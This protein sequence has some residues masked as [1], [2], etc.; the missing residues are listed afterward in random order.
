MEFERFIVKLEEV[1][2]YEGPQK[3]V[4]PDKNTFKVGTQALRELYDNDIE[5][6]ELINN[7]DVLGV[8]RKVEAILARYGSLSE[9]DDWFKKLDFKSIYNSFMVVYNYHQSNDFYRHLERANLKPDTYYDNHHARRYI[10]DYIKED[11][12][13]K[14]CYDQ[15]KNYDFS[16]L[17]EISS[18]MAKISDAEFILS[19]YALMY[20][21]DYL[22]RK[23]RNR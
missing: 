15:V 9:Y 2:N 20:E 11:M 21:P 6:R 13:I 23:E 18:R 19:T 22:Q 17:H 1:Y 5:I 12:L 16:K 3:I 8:I 10:N 4:K 14:D 7:G